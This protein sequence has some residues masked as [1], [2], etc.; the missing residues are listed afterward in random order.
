MIIISS[1]YLYFLPVFIIDKQIS[2]QHLNIILYIFIIILTLIGMCTSILVLSLMFYHRL[3][4]RKHAIDYLLLSNSYVSLLCSS[5]L[6]LDMCVYSIYRYLHSESLFSGFWWLQGGSVIFQG[7]Q[8]TNSYEVSLNVDV[9]LSHTPTSFQ[10]SWTGIRVLLDALDFPVVERK[11][12]TTHENFEKT[13]PSSAL[14]GYWKE[15]NSESW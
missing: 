6:F 12:F 14:F 2:I 5:P 1:E 3:K 4:V 8:S 7:T 15:N 10:L 9:H 13:R 11:D